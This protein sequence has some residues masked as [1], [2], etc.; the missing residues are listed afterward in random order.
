MSNTGMGMPNAQSSIQPTFPF[1]FF[2]IF[3]IPSL[4]VP[5]LLPANYGAG[6][7]QLSGFALSFGC[8]ELLS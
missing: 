2:K 5:R 4:G 7:F 1:S 8:L 3:I 6:L